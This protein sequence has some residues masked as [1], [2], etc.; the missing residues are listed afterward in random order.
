MGITSHDPDPDLQAAC[1]HGPVQEKAMN[2][3]PNAPADLL[4]RGWGSPAQRSLLLRAEP[5]STRRRILPLSPEPGLRD[6]IHQTAENK[7]REL[8]T[9]TSPT[10]QI[11]SGS[12]GLLEER[13]MNPERRSMPR[14]YPKPPNP[15]L[16]GTCNPSWNSG[17]EI[18][19]TLFIHS[20]FLK[21]HTLLKQRVHHWTVRLVTSVCSAGCSQPATDDILLSA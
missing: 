14:S 6:L 2:L 11:A 15:F 21:I 7:S 20:Q 5:K 13:E 9:L 18:R 10:Q 16:C 4:A 1:S 3:P 12:H 8:T 17:V 19:E